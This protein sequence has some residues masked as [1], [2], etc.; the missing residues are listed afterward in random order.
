M[1]VSYSSEAIHHTS[2]SLGRPSLASPAA[3]RLVSTLTAVVAAIA[4][5]KSGVAAGDYQPISTA[6]TQNYLSDIL[7]L[8][9]KQFD[10]TATAV[11]PHDDDD[12]RGSSTP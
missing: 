4:A 1:A 5:A 11:I 9:I 12:C 7:N 6:N 10:L 8:N 2:T 3:L